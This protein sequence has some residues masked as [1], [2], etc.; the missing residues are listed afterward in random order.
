MVLIQTMDI[1]YLVKNCVTNEE[2]TY[3]LRSL[4]NLP[5]NRVFIVGGCPT[6]LNK[7]KL[8][9]CPISQGN[10]R[11]TN[12]TNSLK[13][14]CQDERLSENFIL[15]N[16]DFFIL[17]PIIDPETELNLCRGTIQEV[18]QEIG[19]RYE[20]GSPYLTGMKQTH[21]YLR[22]LGYSKPLSYEL[23]T[24]MVI[25]KKRFLDVFSLPYIETIRKGHIRSI[26][27]NLYLKDSQKIRDVKVYQNFYTPLGS[28]KFLSTEDNSW[29]RVK[30]YLGVIFP[31]KS[32]YE[33]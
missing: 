32:P 25:N 8:I 27:G 29:P 21:I 11:Y 17:K 2:L 18:I 30:N 3:S 23:H 6:N 9:H 12:T 26:Y 13:H 5:H 15:M 7:S 22:D 4:S 31:E 1:V 14:I 28:D 19:H 24:P 20:T 33:L 10:D 16:D